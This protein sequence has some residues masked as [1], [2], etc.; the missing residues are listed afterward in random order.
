MNTR[1]FS[2]LRESLPEPVRQ[3]AG[4]VSLTF[5]V[6]FSFY[7]LNVFFGQ[8]DEL[9]EKMK[10]EEARIAEANKLS[11]IISTLPSGILTFYE[12]SNNYNLSKEQYE[13]VCKITKIIPQRAIMGAN[14]INFK[15]TQIYNTNGNQIAETFVNWDEKENKCMAGFVLIGSVDGEEKEKIT[16]SGEVLNFLSTG[17]DTRVYFI[18]NF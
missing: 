10:K 7:I 6:I 15:A 14:L 11:K 18:K 3:F 5:V 2:K 8:G 16:V 1:Y 17:I 4:L 13:T 9:V 12:G